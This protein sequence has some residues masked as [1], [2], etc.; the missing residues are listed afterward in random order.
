M[1]VTA[2]YYRLVVSLSLSLPVAPSNVRYIHTDTIAV[3]VI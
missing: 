1:Y 3:S 2:L